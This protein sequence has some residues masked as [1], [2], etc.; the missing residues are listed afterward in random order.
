MT[1]RLAL[2]LS[3]L[4]FISTSCMDSSDLQIYAEE[5][6]NTIRIAGSTTV[7]PLMRQL[8]LVYESEHPDIRIDIQ[9]IGTSAGVIATIEGVSH[10]SMASRYFSQEELAQGLVAMPFALDGIALVVHPDNPINDLTLEEVTKIFKGEINNWRQVGGIDAEI[11]V[12]SREE[13]SGIRSSFEELANLEVDIERNGNIY[14]DSQIAKNAIYEKGTGAVK[15]A[16]RANKNTIGYI[17]TGVLDDTVKSVKIDGVGFSEETVRNG[18]YVFANTFLIAT[19][20][21]V[22]LGVQAFIDFIFSE[23]GQALIN[24]LGYVSIG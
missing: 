9:E 13:G 2:L 16:V 21:E 5:N 4:L 12:V 7:T 3:F 8:R 18:D 11:I 15:G 20:E 19:K 17:T 23:E 10:I 22:P 1:K 14:K 24:E 6:I